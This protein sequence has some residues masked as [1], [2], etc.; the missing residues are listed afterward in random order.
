MCTNICQLQLSM[1]TSPVDLNIVTIGNM[2][3]DSKPVETDG[4]RGRCRGITVDPGAGE[5]VVKPDDWPN[6]D[7]KPSKGSVKGQRHV[8]PGGEKEDN[9][10]ESTVKVGSRTTRWRRH[11]KSSDIPRSQG[12]QAAACSVRGERQR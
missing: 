5:S 2:S 9:P 4:K 1:M 8:G 3:I 6:V 7:L 10:G 11:L 12:P